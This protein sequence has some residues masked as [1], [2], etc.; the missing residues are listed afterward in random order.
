M[1]GTGGSRK[2]L[3][4]LHEFICSLIHS[5]LH[6]PSYLPVPLVTHWSIHFSIYP[7]FVHSSTIHP[8]L[9]PSINSTFHPP[10]NLPNRHLLSVYSVTDTVL[11][12][13]DILVNKRTNTQPLKNV[14]TVFLPFVNPFTHPFISPPTRSCSRLATHPYLPLLLHPP[15]LQPHPEYLHCGG[16]CAGHTELSQTQSLPM[17]CY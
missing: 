8:S 13:W 17:L 6:L 2:D 7:S 9:Y 10:F 1:S 14:C 11:G 15:I 5:A 16:P 12:T 3:P 4:L